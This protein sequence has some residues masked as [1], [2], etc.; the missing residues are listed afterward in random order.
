MSFYNTAVEHEQTIFSLSA[1][2]GLAASKPIN[3]TL[4]DSI[5]YVVRCG[6]LI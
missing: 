2:S 3:T 4:F 1:A 5:L 6:L